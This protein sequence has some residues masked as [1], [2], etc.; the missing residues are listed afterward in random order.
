ML[1]G[2]LHILI[3]ACVAAAFF[4][5]K[6]TRSK[7]LRNRSKTLIESAT[8]DADVSILIPNFCIAETYS[9]F[10]KYCWGTW[11]KHVK[12]SNRLTKPQLKKAQDAFGG[13]IHNGK[14]ILQHELNRYHVICV[15]LI[16]PINA[17]YKIVRDRTKKKN[18][19]PASSFDMLFISMGIWL[20]KQ[21]GREHFVMATGDERIEQI[22]RR[23]RSEKLSKPMKDY[24]KS[25]AKLLS[26]NYNPDI[27]PTVIDLIHAT[28]P[29]LRIAFPNWDVDW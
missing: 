18:V 6:T 15:D 3:D 7:H 16:S 5:P 20:Q 17:H 26:M 10:E 2:R 4:A 27:Y 9:T 12:R 21:L 1:V 22:V 19:V 11:N 8:A 14:T 28:K 13:A 23:A 24:L 25:K 29:Q